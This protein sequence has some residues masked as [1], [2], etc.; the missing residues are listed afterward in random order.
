MSKSSSSSDEWLEARSRLFLSPEASLSESDSC[1]SR[2]VGDGPSS[3]TLDTSDGD[4][5]AIDSLFT[6]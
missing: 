2:L 6:H 4:H 1:P 3:V 5:H